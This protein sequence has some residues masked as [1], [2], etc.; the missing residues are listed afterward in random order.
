MKT[1]LRAATAL[2]VLALAT[3]AFAQQSA[4]SDARFGLGVG[5]TAT[6]TSPDLGT[7]LFI[8]LNVAPNIR[9]EPF[10]GWA[11]S[12]MDPTPAGGGSFG[13]PTPGGKSSD[14]TLGVGA[15]LVQ[16]VAT[17]VQL[18]AGGRLGSQ[19]QSFKT[20]A[21]KIERRNT[22]LAIAAGGEYMPVPRVAFGAELQIAY[23]A[24]GDTK[25]TATAGGSVEGGGGSANGTQGTV[26][27]R[28]YLF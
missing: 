22:L 11:R 4:K 26:F 14:F 27:A 6:S 9:I 12:D 3:P 1:L 19:W 28:F 24:I 25:S 20:P 2:T 7:L 16:P 10:I 18:Y 23:L 5:L 17:Q 8:P 21:G 15:F 13:S